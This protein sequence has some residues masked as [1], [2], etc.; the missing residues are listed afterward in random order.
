[1]SEQL[2]A[3][4]D[5]IKDGLVR[6]LLTINAIE[7]EVENDAPD[8][9]NPREDTPMLKVSP[10]TDVTSIT[11]A[12]QKSYPLELN[13]RPPDEE[14]LYWEL[15]DGG[16]WFDIAMEEVKDI[17]L[18]DFRFYIESK[19]P[20][21]LAYYIQNVEHKIEWLQKDE[22]SNE[23]RSLSNFKKK[24]KR[25]LVSEKESYSGAEVMKCA[26]MLGRSFRKIDIR[27]NS[28]MVKFNTDKGRLEPLLIGIADRLGYLVK[29]LDKETIVKE[30]AKGNSVSH[31]V[32]LK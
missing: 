9:V 13:T 6:I 15:K 24:F 1:M 22:K 21:Y 26:D 18:S 11:E 5:P 10:D 23:I 8:F 14:R 28:A 17:W 16:I 30:D 25:P 20:R 32:S 12:F 4:R 19:K 3:F 31:A 7:T 29:A 27:T 2:A